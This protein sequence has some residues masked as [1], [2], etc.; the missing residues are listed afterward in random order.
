MILRPNVFIIYMYIFLA[1]NSNSEGSDCVGE[2]TKKM[3][4][5]MFM[6]KPDKE[7]AMKQLWIHVCSGH[8]LLS[9]GSP[10]KF[11]TIFLNKISNLSFSF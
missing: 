6:K 3:F 2:N 4:P 10:H 7:E 11:F 1:C 9:F 8:G 5:A